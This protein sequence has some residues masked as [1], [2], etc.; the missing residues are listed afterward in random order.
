[1][2]T[3][4]KGD[5]FTSPAKLI[6]NTVNTVGVMGKGV[7]LEYKNRYPEMFRMYKE[8]CDTKRL[9]V[10]KLA[11]W[12]GESKWVLLFPTKKHWRN[13]SKLEYVESG[14]RKFADNWD[15]I[16]VNSVAFP[17]LGCG[18]GGLNWDEVRPLMEKYLNPLPI[19]V[20]VYVDK[21]DDPKPEH[22]D[23]TE[24]EKWLSGEAETIGYEKFRIKLRNF[25]AHNE[26]DTITE[27]NGMIFINENCIDEA[28]IC[29]FWNWIKDAGIF[30]VS[31]IPE[32]YKEVSK[33]LI[34]VM[35]ELNY[36][37]RIFISGDGVNF[38]EQANGFQYIEEANV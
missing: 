8:L 14:L 7:A 11:L 10:G 19:Q 33:V 36:L 20:F 18:N 35:Y 9:D 27:K 31:D 15:S 5:I 38:P 28:D 29:N 3:Y 23:V 2:I 32:I 34:K 22:E 24:I 25:I 1:M 12:K 13:P 26:N 6:V 16:G 4:V 30:T 17:R 21:Y 37:S